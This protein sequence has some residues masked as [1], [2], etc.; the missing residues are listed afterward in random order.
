[1]V[2]EERRLR[3]P[4]AAGETTAGLAGREYLRYPA[5]AATAALAQAPDIARLRRADQ[6]HA[7]PAGGGR[8]VR[9]LVAHLVERPP[10]KREAAGSNPA[11]STWHRHTN[12]VVAQR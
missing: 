5:N 11:G 8:G 10:C 6:A 7:R 4:A 9:G 2:G 3:G 1:M 12:V